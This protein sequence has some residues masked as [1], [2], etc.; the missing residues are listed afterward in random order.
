MMERGFG[1]LNVSWCR[2]LKRL[3]G[4]LENLSFVV[5]TCVVLHIVFQFSADNYV[6]DDNILEEILNQEQ[7][8]R[9]QRRNKNRNP[10]PKANILRLFF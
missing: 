1:I 2:L 9:N 10:G 6:N 8:I 5:I 7:H 3:D 4:N